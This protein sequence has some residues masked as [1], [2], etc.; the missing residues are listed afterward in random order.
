MNTYNSFNELAT[1]N[2]APLRSDMSV[3]NAKHVENEDEDSTPLP[4]VIKMDKG[5][6]VLFFIDEYGMYNYYTQSEGHGG[7]S[8]SSASGAMAYYQSL[9]NPHTPEEKA[10]ADAL[11][12]QYQSIGNGDCPPVQRVARFTHR[13]K[14]YRSLS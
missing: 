9:R 2:A 6:P 10:A 3:F 5:E 1:A 11:F 8:P 12:S 4:C 14:T 7:G 13:G